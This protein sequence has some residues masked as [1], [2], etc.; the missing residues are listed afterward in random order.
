M[1]ALMN[2][3][4][5]INTAATDL[6]P[7][8]NSLGLTILLQSRGGPYIYGHIMDFLC[9]DEDDHQ[10]VRVASNSDGPPNSYR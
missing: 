5:A 9:R 2:F 1:V 4:E 7:E 10:D 3:P 6:F 8:Y